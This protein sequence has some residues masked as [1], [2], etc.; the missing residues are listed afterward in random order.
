MNKN[1]DYT[2]GKT[3]IFLFVFFLLAQSGFAQNQLS[4]YGYFST[5][6]EKQFET[7]SSS[8]V[9]FE[10][11]PSEWTYPFFNLMIQDQI[12]D[13]VKVFINF[14]GAKASNL[15]VRN[16]WGEYSFSNYLN[17]RL[18]KIYRKFGLYNEILDAVPTYYGIEP[19]ELF[20]ADHLMISRTTTVMVFGHLDIS[21]SKLNYSLTTD[22]GE[23]G[24][25]KGVIPVGMD[26]NYKFGDG[27]FTVGTSAYTSGG[28]AVPDID[29]GKGSPKSGVLPW[30]DV[31]KFTVFG[32]YF[33]MNFSNLLIQ[34]EYWQ[35]DHNAVRNPESM[36]TLVQN[37][38]LTDNNLERFF[39]DEDAD[40]NELTTSDVITKADFSIK[41]WYI[42]AGYSIFSSF[43]EI[44][45]Y[46]QLDWY[47]NP[48]T[49]ENKTYGGDEEAGSADDGVFTKSTV[50]VVFRPI[51]ELAIKLDQSFHFYQGNDLADD[52][53]IYY[54]EVRLDVSYIFGN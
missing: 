50:G 19:P 41:T 35:S 30:M 32:G 6:Y 28:N 20:D 39:G 36:I 11:P 21:D 46:V 38:G 18:G 54:P 23:G 16:F 53:D 7:R 17:I 27:N 22:N 1:T 24:S 3:A 29:L 12:N 5:R 25:V 45:P 8:G 42:K 48:E 52:Q 49:I 40:P 15:D 43:G 33:E 51:P 47:S 34:A 26:L 2:L 13:N 9:V 10:A 44:A 31:D 14:N 4:I 37:A